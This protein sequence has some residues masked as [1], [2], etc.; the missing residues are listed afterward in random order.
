MIV[1]AFG[2]RTLGKKRSR[3]SRDI[4]PAHNWLEK[5][6]VP[7]TPLQTLVKGGGSL[8]FKMAWDMGREAL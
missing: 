3:R 1:R 6:A 5:S 2:L 8:L 7:A 4:Y